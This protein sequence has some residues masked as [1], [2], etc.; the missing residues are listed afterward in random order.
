[1]ANH[2]LECPECKKHNVLPGRDVCAYCLV[3]KAA[4]YTSNERSRYELQ[5]DLLCGLFDMLEHITKRVDTLR[6]KG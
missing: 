3:K 2:I 6:Y 1:M 5:L 4:W